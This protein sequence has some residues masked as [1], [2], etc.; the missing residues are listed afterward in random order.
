MAHEYGVNSEQHMPGEHTPTRQARCVCGDAAA[1]HPA[2]GD[3]PMPDYH[4]RTL[5]K[6]STPPACRSQSDGWAGAHR[7][8]AVRP[9]PRGARRERPPDRWC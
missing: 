6:R 7:H 3:G 1:E 9:R 4:G 2:E 8:L 5:P